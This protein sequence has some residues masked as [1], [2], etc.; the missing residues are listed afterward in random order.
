[1]LDVASLRRFAPFFLAALA[2]IGPIV[3]CSADG[4]GVEPG[5]EPE[6]GTDPTSQLPPP[7]N[8]DATPP[9]DAGKDA[10]KDSG[11][12]ASDAGKDAGPPPPNPGDACTK[13]QQ[14]F[15]KP[16][17]KCGTQSAICL[18][19]T[20]TDY[21]PC[22]NEVGACVPGETQTC[23]NC[24]KQSC[25]NYCAW[26]ACTGEPVGGCTPTSH[27][28]STVGCPT[29]GTYRTRDCSD[30]C[31]WSSYSAT[32]G[33]VM[34]RLTASTNVG[35]TV[36]GIFPFRTT[37]TDFRVTGTCPNA[38][39]S[40]TKTQYFYVEVVN[41]SAQQI[42]ASV[43]HTYPVAGGTAID[44]VMAAYDGNV[45]PID[46]A[47]RKACAKGVNDV[48]PTATLPCG[49]SSWAGLTGANAVVIPPL[50]SSLIYSAVYGTS[51]T[52]KGD[53]KLVVRTD[54]VE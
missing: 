54:L 16:C 41:P 38:T 12:D 32:C 20:V 25:T 45:R 50:S 51:T 29:P 23:G 44:T 10:A 11:I 2:A 5:E 18:N 30:T 43:W 48:C 19:G 35:E 13:E 22:E 17:G 9:P 4:E 52:D 27:D 6:A 42:T 53:V 21:G 33:D 26:T 28:Y 49:S 3:A 14:V 34:F 46:D 47:S 15:T 39:L 36:S 37:L 7:S 24:G 40:T 31:A 1:M 8:P